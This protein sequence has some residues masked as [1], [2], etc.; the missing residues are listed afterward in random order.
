M[1]KYI[2]LNLKDIFKVGGLFVVKIKLIIA[3]DFQKS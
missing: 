2:L 3:F 1:V